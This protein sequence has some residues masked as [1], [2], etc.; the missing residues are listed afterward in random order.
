MDADQAKSA[1]PEKTD[2]LVRQRLSVVELHERALDEDLVNEV[3]GL[4]CAAEHLELEALNIDLEQ[5][6]S[7]E[8]LRQELVE[9]GTLT[10]SDRSYSVPGN[11]A[12]WRAPIVSS[13]D[14]SSAADTWS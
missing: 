8:L 6:W 10:S 13:E 9:R 11:S 12:T 1:S 7:R 2:D 3:Q 14:E 4:P 5:P